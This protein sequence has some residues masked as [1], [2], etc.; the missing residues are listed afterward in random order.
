MSTGLVV[1]MRFPYSL[2][3][4]DTDAESSWKTGL[5]EED[6]KEDEEENPKKCVGGGKGEGRSL[7]RCVERTLWRTSLR[8]LTPG[9][10]QIS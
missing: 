8:G 7:M 10:E 2:A 3:R 9:W 5:E 4:R 6:D 1:E